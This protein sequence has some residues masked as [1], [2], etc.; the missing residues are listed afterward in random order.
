MLRSKEMQ[1]N[2]SEILPTSESLLWD[3]HSPESRSK[4]N[5]F[6]ELRKMGKLFVV[7]R[8]SDARGNIPEEYCID[9]SS[10]ATAGPQRPYDEM[11]HHKGIGLIVN[12]THFDGGVFKLGI[13]PAG[14]GG[15]LAKEKQMSTETTEDKEGL[16]RFVEK[17]KSPDPLI[18]SIFNANRISSYTDKDVLAAIQDHRTG[19]IYPLAVFSN[20]GREIKMNLPMRYL[21]H[22]QYDPSKIYQNGIPALKDEDFPQSVLEFLT[23]NRKQV[24]Y[25]KESFPDISDKL[26]DQNPEFLVITT[27]K[28]SARGRYANTLREPGSYFQIHIP[29]EKENGKRTKISQQTI[30]TI[31]EQAEYPIKHF[32]NIHTVLIETGDI[33]QSIRIA[34]SYVTVDLLRTWT[35]NPYHQ[36]LLSE[37]SQEETKEIGVFTK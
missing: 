23:L 16:D 10:I 37:V 22:G 32:S 34:A 7:R 13:R 18:Q 26:K 31:I 9:T 21:M 36:I 20:S 17:I 24:N 28:M 5:K 27:S 4:R 35:H 30:D 29:A 2:T 14:C 15:L 11:I 8:C 33:E 1:E 12:L 19:M 6:F 3:N 25:L